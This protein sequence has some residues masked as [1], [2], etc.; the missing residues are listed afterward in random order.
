[1]KVKR[2]IIIVSVIVLLLLV[3]AAFLVSRMKSNVMSNTE[4]SIM[5]RSSSISQ[6]IKSYFNSFLEEAETNFIY[7]DYEKLLLTSDKSSDYYRN[8]RKFIVK[9][10]ELLEE[11]TL[12]NGKVSRNIVRT[13]YN[14]IDMEAIEPNAT[15]LSDES[16][17][18]L[19]NGTIEYHFPLFD[20]NGNLS[21]NVKLI[22]NF[23]E[24]VRTILT[25][26]N[27]DKSIWILAGKDN[28][29]VLTQTYN[30][31]YNKT[32]SLSLANFSN[33][34][35]EIGRGLSG[36]SQGSILLNKTSIPVV[37]AYNPVSILDQNYFLIYAQEKGKLFSTINYITTTLS[38]IFALILAISIWTFIYFVKKLKKGEERLL[39]IQ[40]AV[41]N[42]SDLIIITD[43][44]KKTLFLNKTFMEL[45]KVDVNHQG[46][47]IELMI[48]DASLIESID[49][50]MRD[51]RSFVG[52]FELQSSLEEPTTCL[53][54]ADVIHDSENKP[55]GI[56]YMVTDIAERKKAERM[57]NEFISTVSHELR[58]PLTSIRGSLGL[59]RG[60]VTG[61]IPQQTLKLVDIAYTNSERLVRLI[62]DILDIEKIEAGKMEFHI[63]RLELI[64]IVEKSIEMMRNF[65]NQYNVQL[66]LNKT[67]PNIESYID[68]DR[69]EQVLVNLMSNAAKF[70]PAGSTINIEMSMTSQSVVKIS[71]IDQGIGIPDEFKSM[72][73]K[74]FAQVDA[75]D[76]KAKGGTGLGLS[77][78]KAIVEKF[79]GKI[80]C[81]SVQGKGST[82]YIEIPAI[83][84][85]T[86]EEV[87]SIDSN[88]PKILIV[89]DDADI[90][91]LLKMILEDAGY[92]TAIAYTAEDA[93]VKLNS[94]NF[95]AIT[96]DLL[97]PDKQGI[98]LVQELRE[99]DKT[100]KLP[101]IV[102]SAVANQQKQQFMGN[103]DI[104]DWIQKPIDLSRLKRALQQ[105]IYP[106]NNDKY[107]ILHVEDDEDNTIIVSQILKDKASI[108][109][110]NSLLK[111]KEMVKTEHFELVIL[112]IGLPDGN[113][114]EL[115]PYLRKC[116]K[117]SIPVLVFS[118]S[119]TTTNIDTEVAA[120]LVKSKT[121]NEDLIDMIQ[122]ILG[123]ANYDNKQDNDIKV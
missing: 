11:V 106:A 61:E 57:K 31:I 69:L 105:T 23:K 35:A 81:D 52:E 7:H 122:S 67:V 107:T 86:E 28:R 85:D 91:A 38:A 33:A 40:T 65:A 75:S 110:A 45:F 82:F 114:L 77:I 60:G 104:V 41:N 51:D 70:S 98:Q 44:E 29:V 42:A 47:P 123:H 119:E 30:P 50:K 84:K 32:D 2:A 108:I 17:W 100:A 92:R 79:G 101:V 88:V 22:L 36:S 96:L 56:M 78:S 49:S 13:G 48:N 26:D 116:G 9:H 4:E 15:V 89:E 6:T 109:H 16:N 94:D 59:I 24:F 37:Y 76:S 93:K 115:L 113:G 102:V 87:D 99:D 111:A 112:D 25:K 71:V 80:D 62:N 10:Q 19:F 121:N 34:F 103:F 55:L 14:Q 20:S 68:A 120:S 43:M 72:L 64:P 97:L 39:R 27:V 21:S 117:Q 54:R 12:Y 18:Q 8:L 118:A 63:Q 95:A 90:A 58:T 53:L 46:N 74:K 83:V 3:L 1:V 66:K 73:F 5:K